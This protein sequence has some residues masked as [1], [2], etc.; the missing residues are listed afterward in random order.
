M[1]NFKQLLI[2]LAVALTA[3]LALAQSFPAKQITI[4]TSFPVGSGPDGLI[5]KTLPEFSKTWGVPVILE[6][7][8]GGQGGVALEAFKQSV[9]TVQNYHILYIE[10]AVVWAYPLI[11]GKDDL[12]KNIKPIVPSHYADLALVVSPKINTRDDLIAAIKTSPNYGSWGI[13]S[14]GHVASAQVA[15][16]LNL[17]AEH[18]PYKDYNQW[19]IDV[20]NQQLAYSFSTLGSARALEQAGKIKF[21]A[22]G[23]DKRDPMYPNVPTIYEFFGKNFKYHPLGAMATFYTKDTTPTA[24][25]QLVRNGLRETFAR[26][27][28]KADVTARAYKQWTAD[29]TQT[30]RIFAQDSAEYLKMLKEFNIEMKP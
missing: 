18:I 20:S 30:G 19:M 16:G 13:G 10:S 11:A 21:L 9:D 14:Q 28:V 3:P 8:P 1:K 5:R 29:P 23:T 27:E 4:I 2:A 25:E 24:T 15:K 12:T 6:N 26:P 17:K 22:V 7:R